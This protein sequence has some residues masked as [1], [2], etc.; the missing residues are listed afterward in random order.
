MCYCNCPN[1]N[2]MG[3]CR[4]RK[5]GACPIDEDYQEAKEAHEAALDD[6]ADAEREERQL[7]LLDLCRD[8]ADAGDELARLREEDRVRI[9]NTPPW[10]GAA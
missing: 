6:K 4:G 1:E 7:G 10:R 2:S 8:L 3:E 5:Y 9:A